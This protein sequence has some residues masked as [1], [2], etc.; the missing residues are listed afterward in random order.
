MLR[1]RSLLAS[2]ALALSVLAATAGAAGA[3]TIDPGLRAALAAKGDGAQVDVMMLFDDAFDYAALDRGLDGATPEARRA[4]VVAALKKRADA[5]QAEARRTLDAAVR[6]GRAAQVRVLWLANALAFRG[7]ATAV[8][9]LA[10]TKSAAT[11]IYDRPYDMAG[12]VT[13]APRT[14]DR[15]RTADAALLAPAAVDTAW[16]VKWV[17]ANR[18]WIETG[19]RGNGIVVAHFDTGVWLTHPDIANRLWVNAGEIPGNGLDDDGNGYVDDVYGYD[20][21]DFDGDPN[22]DV[23]GTAANHGTHTAG[24]VAGDG[25]NGTI[26]GVAPGARVLVC[27]VFKTDGTGAP[28]S[29]I[30]EGEQ[31]AI[32]EGARVF[33]M[34]LGIA[35]NLPVS[36][37]KTER[38]NADGIRAAGV[39]FFNAAGNDHATYDPPYELGVT[40]RVPAPWHAAGTPWSSRGGVIAVG[41][42]GYKS[43]ISY[44]ASSWGPAYWGDVPPWNDWPSPT[45]IVKPDIC[46]PA[47]YVNSLLKPSGYSG[48]TWSGTSMAT[49]HAAGVAALMLSKNPSLSPAG[50]DSI[51]EQT[52]VPLGTVGKDN[53]YGAGELNALAA[54]NAVPTALRPY[55]VRAAVAIQDANA[56]GVI[57]PGESFNLLVTLKNNSQ[58]VGATGVTAGLAVAPNPYVT[59]T[60]GAAAYPDLGA[61]GGT[62]VNT[63]DPFSLT[64]GAAAPQGYLFTCRLTMFAA[65]GYQ[66]TEDFK[67]AVGLPEYRDHDAGQVYLT[68]TDQGILGYMSDALAVGSGFGRVGDYSSL[69]VGSFWAGTGATYICNRDY[70]GTSAGTTVETYE[71]VSS[72]APLGRVAAISGGVAPQEY[73]AIFNDSGHA[74]PLGL[75]VTQRSYAWADA[76][77][78]DFVVLKYTIHNNGAAAVTDYHTGVF[79]DWDLGNSS[80]NYGGSDAGRHLT[81]MYENAAGPY[82][83]I[84][85]LSPHVH[86]NLTLI[87]NVTYV[88]PEGSIDDGI[89]ARHLKG[90]MSLPTATVASDYS[91]LT[92]A[93]PFTI[94]PGAEITVA[95]ALVYGDNLADLQANTDAAQLMYY[96]TPVADLPAAP[97]L[98]LE[99]NRPNPFNPATLISYSLEREG[100]VTVTVFDLGGRRLRTL[101]QGVLAPGRHAVAWDGTDENGA[102]QPSG[103]YLYRLQADGRSLTRKMMLVK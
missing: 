85:L 22:D 27:K 98:G 10:A 75:V 16:G 34:S 87:D 86:R 65:G 46:A 54:V 77:N 79:C 41:G 29:A 9:A 60:D 101:E 95:F 52:A 96:V 23:T 88:Y 73:Q 44:T 42:T 47:V 40:A 2:L 3:A 55:L 26:T 8:Q 71:W 28:F 36:L 6:D 89:K 7:D 30:Y 4:A 58:V 48:D 49:P 97:A 19:Y 21:A 61:F 68:V 93:G 99:Q 84:A 66:T 94:D 57:D 51:I 62:A 25:T 80:A 90:T 12:G 100:P 15:P 32:M 53:T 63:G 92:S 64:A 82:V 72:V 81:Y 91:A 59:V 5:G 24:T 69:Y 56:N 17:K 74:T 83:G 38:Q 37:H 35:G 14:D 31:Y 102:R 76:A 39:T 45:G 67:L 20:F 43:N 11:L 18:V 78:Q 1:R 70:S 13:A 50:I 103:M 33:T